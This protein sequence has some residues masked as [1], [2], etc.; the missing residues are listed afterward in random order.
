MRAPDKPARVKILVDAG[1]ALG[2]ALTIER[3]EAVLANLEDVETE[4]LRGAVRRHMAD[5]DR[6]R[7]FP[8]PADLRAKLPRDLSG[9]HLGAD[10]AWAIVVESFD[11]RASVLWT[12]EIE[13]ARCV[14]M[15]IWHLGDKIGAR[16]AFRDAYTAAVSATATPPRWKVSAG[17]DKAQRAALVA[18]ATAAGLLG[19]SQAKHLAA[20]E[21]QVSDAMAKVAGLIAGGQSNVVRFPDRLALSNG[22]TED[23]REKLARLVGAMR[24]GMEKAER[25]RAEQEATAQAERDRARQSEE[26]RRAELLAQAGLVVNDG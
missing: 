22:A 4:A 24:E 19:P 15:P 20:P 21:A 2:T 18:R 23:D 16:M 3:I 10:S 14:A 17:T 26:A 13:N 6:G 25:S 9:V 5:P 11:E 7:F 1:L 8:T 12:A